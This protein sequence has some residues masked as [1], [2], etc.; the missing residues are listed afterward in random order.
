VP[1]VPLPRAL[2]DEAIQAGSQ[3][4]RE[5]AKRHQRFLAL[6]YEPSYDTLDWLAS[7]AEGTHSVHEL[8]IFGRV[9]VLEFIPRTS[10]EPSR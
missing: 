7:N 5:A 4:L 6:A 3:F 1:V 10:A 9:E 2:N 8:G